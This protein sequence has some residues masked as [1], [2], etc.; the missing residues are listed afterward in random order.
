M[1]VLAVRLSNVSN[2]V[3]KLH[4]E[5]SRN[6]WKNI[7]HGLMD[8]EVPITSVTN[9][10]HTSTWVSPDMVQLYDRYLGAGW[11]LKPNDELCGNAL[12]PFPMLSF[13]EPTKDAG[14]GWFPLPVED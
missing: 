6:M 13:G 11:G 9:G 12:I 7:W 8:K 4:G 5:V 14:K 1:T 2:G 10:V 3:S